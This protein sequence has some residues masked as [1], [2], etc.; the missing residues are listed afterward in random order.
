MSSFGRFQYLADVPS[1]VT[2]T[3]EDDRPMHLLLLADDRHPANV[4]IDHINEIVALSKSVITL[5][6]PRRISDP[7]WL[8]PFPFDVILVHYSIFILSETYLSGL[9]KDYITSFPGVR[10]IIHEDE[11]QQIDKFRKTIAELGMDAVFSC[12]DTPETMAKVYDVEA[13]SNVSFYSCLPGYIARNFAQF[14]ASPIAER[15]LDIIYRGRVLPAQL[16]RLG[17][18]KRTIG[19]QVEALASPL[20]L[21]TDI[22]SGEADRIYGEAWPAFLTSGRAMLGVEGGASIF[23]FD[24]SLAAAV[25]D[26]QAAHPAAGFDEIWQALLK[27]HEGNVDFRTITPKF[28]EAIAAKTALILYPGAYNGILRAD[29]HFIPLNRDGSNFADV[30]GKL[31]DTD[32]L[33]AMVDRTFDEIMGREDLMTSFYTMKLDAV[34]RR[35]WQRQQEHSKVPLVRTIRQQNAAAIQLMA[36]LA[37]HQQQAHL[38]LQEIEHKVSHCEQLLDQRMNDLGHIN[39]RIDDLHEHLRRRAIR[40]RLRRYTTEMP[41]HLRRLLHRAKA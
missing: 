37:N 22:S 34:L 40:A 21:K 24:G 35:L 7:E 13:L 15:P 33:Q 32:A 12:L 31:A 11:Y 19:D 14:Q 27:D 1:A 39:Q 17:Q 3:D 18:E 30:A 6:N 20:G 16:G 26:Y 36:D 10:A 9:W 28:F 25:A 41:L 8:A 5:I 38:R 29:D 23:D 4:V 2:A